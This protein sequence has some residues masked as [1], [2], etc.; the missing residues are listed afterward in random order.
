MLYHLP[1]GS[2]DGVVTAL[3][4]KPQI[5]YCPALVSR[6]RTDWQELFLCLVNSSVYRGVEVHKVMGTGGET[7][8]KIVNILSVWS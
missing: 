4:V 5:T 3:G 8:Q 1:G 6:P 7:R 2:D